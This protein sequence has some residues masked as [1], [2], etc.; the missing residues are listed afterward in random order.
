MS[1]SHHV[2]PTRWR[3]I[4]RLP[5]QALVREGGR[6]YAIPTPCRITHP[7]T[8]AGAPWLDGSVTRT[9]GDDAFLQNVEAEVD[10][11]L[12]TE[13]DSAVA[14]GRST[15]YAGRRRERHYERSLYV[16]SCVTATT[17]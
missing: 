10:G 9:E 4:P 1:L 14:R 11:D 15:R 8:L 5:L 16:F 6:A 13:E 3:L 17:D 2:C 12:P 7:G